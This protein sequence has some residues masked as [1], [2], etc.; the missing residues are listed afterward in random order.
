[1]KDTDFKK[2]KYGRLVWDSEGMYYRFEPKELPLDYECNFSIM[3]HSIKTALIL[4][5]LD[6]LTKK[7]SKDEIELIKIPFMFKEARLSSQIEGTKST[8][9]E[10][11]RE[12]KQDEPDRE[13]REGNKEIR[14]YVAALEYGLKHLDEGISEEFIKELHRILL[15][16]VRGQNK[17]PGTYKKYQNAVGD[18][19][20]TYDTAKF[21]PASPERTSQLMK[22]L[23][24]YINDRTENNVFYKIAIIHY[25]FES[26]HPFRDGNG[27]VGRLL[28]M[29][30]LVKEKILTHPLLYF[31]EYFNRN[32]STYT[33]SLYGVSSEGNIE[34]WT[35]FFQNALIN[36]SDRSMILLSNMEDYKKK[37]K[38]EMEGITQGHNI[39]KLVDMLFT[40]PFVRINDVAQELDMSF[41]GAA[42][43]V[44]KLEDRGILEEIN[45]KKTRKVFVAKKILAMLNN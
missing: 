16:G 23:V 21:V 42:N 18:R 34:N 27:R 35:T 13:I 28:I 30:L 43:I 19:E 12:E 37:I 15:K 41:P 3:N 29:L 11:F 5:R 38:T 22:N 24:D 39:H 17:E 6:G 45:G 31:S 26:I 40:N 10:V 20:D 4:G 25:Q 36:Q 7:L 2:T 8:L 1:M 9:E 32:R 44:H 33:E 14:N